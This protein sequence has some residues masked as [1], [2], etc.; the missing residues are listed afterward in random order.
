MA[1]LVA[2]ELVFSGEMQWVK[3]NFVSG[4]RRNQSV[5][6]LVKVGIASEEK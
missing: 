1:S 2:K 4:E 6:L 5:L 3:R